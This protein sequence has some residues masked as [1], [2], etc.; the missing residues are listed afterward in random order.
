MFKDAIR[1]IPVDQEQEF[2]PSS[3]VN[4]GMPFCVQHNVKVMRVGRIADGDLRKFVGY[5]RSELK[6]DLGR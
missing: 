1:V 4:F 3:R 5:Y 2:D 6:K